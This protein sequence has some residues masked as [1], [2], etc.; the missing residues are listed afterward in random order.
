M[1]AWLYYAAC[2][3]AS[4]A[5]SIVGVPILA[6]AC[7]YRDWTYSPNVDS[8]K[9]LPGRA[10]VDTW[11]SPWMR[12]VWGN[13]E[14]G[15]S[16]VYAYGPDWVGPYNDLPP[17]RWTAF[18]WAAVRNRCNGFDYICWRSS[19]TPPIIKK[20]YTTPWGSTRLLQLGWTQLPASDGWVGPYKQRM[21]MSF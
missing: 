14:D 21:V 16:G 9:P 2:Q 18:W 10:K 20:N 3:V 13:P 15:V 8:I 4:L 12:P 17:S 6:Y 5:L 19:S 11:D 1:K 7:Y